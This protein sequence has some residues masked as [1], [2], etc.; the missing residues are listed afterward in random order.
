MCTNN[1]A[2]LRQ[3][4]RSLAQ[5]PKGFKREKRTT[6]T[7]NRSPMPWYGVLCEPC[8]QSHGWHEMLQ[9]MATDKHMRARSDA[10][11]SS[12]R[13][14]RW[15]PNDITWISLTIAENTQLHL[16]KNLYIIH[17]HSSYEMLKNRQRWAKQHFFTCPELT[18]SYEKNVKLRCDIR[19]N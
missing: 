10:Q 13:C 15:R 5:K 18:L 3:D 16:K 9:Q 2:F 11:R 14:H 12:P 17:T 7:C 6:R 4:C 1:D 8:G 19:Q